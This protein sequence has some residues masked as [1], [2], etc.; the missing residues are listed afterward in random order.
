MSEAPHFRFWP[1]GVPRTLHYPQTSLYYN[2]EVSAARYPDKPFLI[3]YDTP[4]GFAAFRRDVDALAG[5]L[6]HECGVKKGERVMLYLQN[7]PQYMIAF[8]AVLRADAVAVP[9]SPMNLAG[10]LRHYAR[11]SGARVAVVGQELL[12]RIAP[13]AG[14]E[15]DHLVVA[16]YSDYLAGG[17]GNAR[18]GAPPDLLAAPRRDVTLA[19]A[20]A[21]REALAAARMPRAH[22]ARPDDLCVLP[23]TSGTTG[24]PKGC[25]HTHRTVMSTTVYSGPWNG[26][27]SDSV[28]LCSLP[29]FH[30]TAMVG[31]MHG[32]IFLGQTVV[33]MQRWD[34]DVAARLIARHRV[35]SWGCI[36][37][38]AIDFLAN[39]D[40]GRHDLSSLARVGGGGAAMPEA[41]AKKLHD[42]TGQEY[43][44]GYGL[45]ET[46]A[47]SHTNPMQRPKRQC[48]GIPIFGVDSRII[49]PETLR[50]LPRGETGEIVIHGPQVFLGYWNNPEATAQAFIELEGKRFFRSG[51]LGRIDE[52]GY[53][54]MVD[55]LKRM[56]NAS[57]M[58]VW[59]AEVEAMMHAHP[60]IQ[61][62]CVV[63]TRDAYRGETVKAVV[64]LRPGRAGQVG[65]DDIVGWCR[66][67]MAAYKVPRIVEIVTAL[68]KSATGKVQW[69]LL[70]QKQDS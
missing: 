7:S 2:L 29:L 57:G 9:V 56:I 19:G 50:E 21:W 61:E 54:F 62:A 58:K 8:Y 17:D 48:L 37:T 45:T 68:P 26:L 70:Q 1:R 49:D 11:D 47:P 39:P 44:E 31:S 13:L 3:F 33:L 23:Y 35:S 27:S 14:A 41:V 10:E 55:R 38:M 30:V 59:P 42:L 16:A 20:V 69:R 22:T 18:G 28:V 46:M 6:Q 60:D 65:A 52:D 24:H 40:L 25:M 36:A 66:G 43:I 4:L 63:A 67:R 5:Y 53:F 12:E 32:P 34:R 51:D 15:F 64:V